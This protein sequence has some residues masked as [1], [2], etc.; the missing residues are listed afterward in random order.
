MAHITNNEVIQHWGNAEQAAVEGHGDEGDFARQYILNPVIF[1]LLGKFSGQRILDA[2]C[3]QGYL[4][5]LMAKQGGIVTGIEPAE[6]FYS[7][8]IKREQAEPLG[9]TY[10]QADL[11][12]CILEENL[13]NYVVANMVFMDIPEYQAAM[14]N[15]VA[16]LKPGGNFIYSITHP[17]FEESAAEW[18]Q[19]GFVAVREY[20]QNYA[21][22]S[23]YGYWFHRPLSEYL[24]LTIQT[25]CTL[26]E[27]VEPQLSQQIVDQHGEQH[28]RNMH[29]PQFLIIH[30]IKS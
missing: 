27:V 9:I 19:K 4:S 10:Y 22:P 18:N 12:A 20:L 6:A 1:R 13:F 28:A 7:Y 23:R 16:M 17:C 8:A 21:I 3:G 25:G 26:R 2:G 30:A 15:C 11:S 29:V 5:R 24:N 14:Q